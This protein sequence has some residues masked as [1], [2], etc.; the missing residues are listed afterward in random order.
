M[1]VD[2]VVEGIIRHQVMSEVTWTEVPKRVKGKE[3]MVIVPAPAPIHMQKS[4][5]YIATILQSSGY[6]FT[7]DDVRRFREEL[8]IPH[9][10][11]RNAQKRAMVRV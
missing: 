9:Q 1:A 8:G 11:T 6:K 7:E 2:P 4:D 5:S 10:F 3:Q